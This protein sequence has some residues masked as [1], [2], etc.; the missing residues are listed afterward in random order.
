[1]IDVRQLRQTLPHFA[2]R[3]GPPPDRGGTFFIRDRNCAEFE[4]QPPR[5]YPHSSLAAARAAVITAACRAGVSS[6]QR[7]FQL[8][9]VPDGEVWTIAK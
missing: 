4:A 2:W 7:A 9:A 6:A 3:Y 5:R 1:M 8:P